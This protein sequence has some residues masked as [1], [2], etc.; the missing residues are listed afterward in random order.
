MGNYTLMLIS[1]NSKSVEHINLEKIHKIKLQHIRN[2][3]IYKWI[4]MS[5]ESNLKIC[6]NIWSEFWS[7]AKIEQNHGQLSTAL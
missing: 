6:S 3:N 1:T 4:E 5:I 7:S 2:P